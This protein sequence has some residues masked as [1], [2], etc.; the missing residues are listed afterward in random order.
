MEER[1]APVVKHRPFQV[2]DCPGGNRPSALALFSSSLRVPNSP[3]SD[4]IRSLQLDA[5]AANRARRLLGLEGL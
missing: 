1:N 3:N 4:T 2:S 5:R